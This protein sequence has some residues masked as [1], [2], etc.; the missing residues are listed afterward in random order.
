VTR[1]DSAAST[2][3]LDDHWMLWRHLVL[4]SA[5]F[6]VDDLLSLGVPECAEAADALVAEDSAVATA[7]FRGAYRTAVDC[8]TAVLRQ[9]A[10]QDGYREALLWQNPRFAR[11]LASCLADGAPR[12][13]SVRRGERTLLAYL[14]R[15]CAKNDTIGFFGP[16]TWA[17]IDETVE[18]IRVEP[19]G[20][21]LA[22]RAVFFEGWAV[23]AV[24][25]AAAA[26]PGV[27]P[28]LWPRRD[29]SVRLEGRT[30]HRPIGP[31]IDL[32]LAEAAVL[33]ACTGEASAR[34]LTAHLL[35]QATPGI[36]TEHDLLQA[37]A[38]LERRRLVTWS[39][40]P[41]FAPDPW[42]EL[43]LRRQLERIAEPTV[44]ARAIEPLERLTA[45]RDEV[46][47]AAGQVDRLEAALRRVEQVFVEV[48]DQAPTRAAGRF[49]GGRTILY[50]DCRRDVDVRIGREVL[51][52]AA[53]PLALVLDSARWLTWRLGEHYRT[54]LRDLYDELTRATG[55][56]VPAPKLLGGLLPLVTGRALGA[57]EPIVVDFQTRWRE[58]LDF[59]PA[60]QS[61]VRTVRAMAGPLAH[62]FAAPAAGWAGAAFQNPD[63]MIA[64][65]GLTAL[66]RG[67]YQL[68]LG[69]LHLAVNSLDALPF[70]LFHP[71][72]AALQR[73][74]DEDATP[75]RFLPLYP[76]GWPNTT[77][78][79]YPPPCV[80]SRNY[81]YISLDGS[82]ADVPADLVLDLTG[83]V[84]EAEGGRL[85]LRA[86]DGARH[87]ALAVLGE[88]I[89]FAIFNL[90]K[91]M[92]PL[93][94]TPRVAIDRLVVAREA[95]RMPLEAV[96]FAGPV[97]GPDGFLAARR[98]AGRLGLPRFVFLRLPG[99][100][101]PIYLDL[102]SPLLVGLA[103]GEIHR[104]RQRDPDGLAVFTEMLPTPDQLW[105]TD[106]AGRRCTC[107]LRLAAVHES[108]RLG[109][110][111][112]HAAGVVPR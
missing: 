106:A 66:E 49:G 30:A 59:D 51:A 94:H 55:P 84:V 56:R 72:P 103:G 1:V 40:E 69:E 112:S 102:A 70:T 22:E 48:T 108:A 83:A 92:P 6:P 8:T 104:V 46:A 35:W 100:L 26:D 64:A 50:E 73:T 36:R 13:Q 63:M 65:A 109:P 29:P 111:A 99:E 96:S 62:R 41:R 79:N 93:P 61:V 82:H 87:D 98:F 17:R 19:A 77:I 24:A 7:A 28:W 95:W 80:R 3:R 74:V 15:Y 16:S 10:R 34:Q 44:R 20:R 2:V 97:P 110:A 81:R 71:E 47:A 107:E 67:D 37:L 54:A 12:N 105:L 31:P 52:A 88:L 43:A 33:R 78:R 57:L 90:F 25:A 14:Q 4:R 39:P 38:A 89:A 60:D 68:V 9:L 58:A 53:A 27:R 91:P 76:R 5:G 32:S 86:P 45:A 23:D 75:A 18:R 85:D 42:P 11:S 21:L 101:K